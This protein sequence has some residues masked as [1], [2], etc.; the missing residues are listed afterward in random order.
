MEI[1]IYDI[2]KKG[3]CIR[4]VVVGKMQIKDALCTNVDSH[5]IVKIC[6]KH[7]NMNKILIEKCCVFFVD[8]NKTLTGIFVWGIGSEFRTT[9]SE[10]YLINAVSLFYPNGI[11]ICHNH[12]NGTCQSSDAD[13][14]AHRLLTTL[15]DKEYQI[16]DNLVIS[17]NEFGST[18]REC[19]LEDEE[20]RRMLNEWKN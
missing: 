17:E 18:K 19:E 11:Y 15:L 1:N 20:A 9:L 3:L 13:K 10:R 14:E 7:F 2:V 6:N 16:I 5:K 4:G 12:P 8:N